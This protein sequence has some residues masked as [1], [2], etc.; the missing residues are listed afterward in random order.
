MNNL[1]KS[2]SQ[3]EQELILKE[4]RLAQREEALINK[5]K[6]LLAKQKELTRYVNNIFEQQERERI[7][8]WLVDSI[9]E[10][11]ELEKV[12]SEIV[13]K[14]GNLLK[15]DRCLI[16]LY[17]SD[18]S[19]FVLKNEYKI[20][21]EIKSL[22]DI[23]VEFSMP[24][25]WMK[26]IIKNNEPVLIND[27]KTLCS[28]ENSN[29]FV[30][31]ADVESV[32]IFPIL[33]KSGILGVIIA[34]QVEYKRVWTEI[35][36]QLLIDVCSQIAIAIR[37]ASLYTKVQETTRLKGEFLTSMSHEFR[38]PLNA[39][40]GFSEMI[41]SG[42]Y[43]ALNVKQS[44]Y[45]NNIA[46]S[47]H[48]LLRLVNDILDLSKIE[49]GNMSL[50]YERFNIAYTI[51]EAVS[52]LKSVAMKKGIEVDFE[53]NDIIISADN[54]RFRQIMYNLLSNAI[55]FTETNGKIEIKT[56]VNGDKL[57]IEIIDNGIGIS[58]K[59]KW[60]IFSEFYQVDSSYT[61][62]QEGTGLGL[63]LTRK[64]IELHKGHIDFDSQINK[65]SK[66]W[67]VVPGVE[68]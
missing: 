36:V 29:N 5:N 41:L 8:K 54:L 59:D 40:I 6:K 38:T 53:V 13:Q 48:H 39:I 62:R 32:A 43:G 10:S 55:K 26:S 7:V 34:N 9:R 50:T 51:N 65:G 19:K 57:K 35:H 17:D 1:E 61:R 33:D 67:F 2:L 49:S 18:E 63:T 42:N 25:D 23:N 27:Y 16:A 20:S 12:L 56:R 46:I 58:E 15:A 66:F 28:N 44:D 14:L 3:K 30:H 45:L 64:L 24:V 22:F 68:L 31:F 21:S 37:Q 60:K 11:L 52:V 47:G 4:K